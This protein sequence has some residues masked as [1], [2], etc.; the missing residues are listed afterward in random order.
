MF[1]ISDQKTFGYIPSPIKLKLELPHIRHGTCRNIY[2][3]LGHRIG[4]GQLCAGGEDARDACPG[5]SGSPLMYFDPRQRRWIVVGIVSL[6][7][8]DCGTSG[9]P[10]V[11]TDVHHYLDWIRRNLS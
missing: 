3:R 8:K 10:G 2:R 4:P 7:T 11:Y 1:Y 5:D 9:V 6:G